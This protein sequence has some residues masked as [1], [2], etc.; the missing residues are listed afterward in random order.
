MG[1]LEQIEINYPSKE[2]V[3]EIAI[4][5]PDP[6]N[7]T[8]FRSEVVTKK[9]RVLMTD[10]EA[11]AYRAEMAVSLLLDKFKDDPDGLANFIAARRV[12]DGKGVEKKG[13]GKKSAKRGKGA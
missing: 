8:R 5:Y 9:S 6:E 3:E 1:L 11:E 12:A 4:S 13:P 10:T 7:P 2:V